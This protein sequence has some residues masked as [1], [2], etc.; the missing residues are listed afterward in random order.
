MNPLYT[1]AKGA[2]AAV[3]AWFVSLVLPAVPAALLCTVMVAANVVSARRLARRL[4]RKYPENSE[5]LKFS[6][7]RFGHAIATVFRIYLLLL[8][9][10]LL[11]RVVTGSAF[12]AL[13]VA[14]GAVTLWQAISILENES[15]EASSPLAA[16]LRKIL[17][18]KTRRHLDI[19]L[20]E[21]SRLR[22][23]K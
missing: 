7:G 17:V 15:T 13:R 10:A 8:V 18:D 12:P 5:R 20:D 6:S 3:G 23:G 22:R 4:A 2:A 14:A 1:L 21:L 16:F 19:D 9:A 11:E